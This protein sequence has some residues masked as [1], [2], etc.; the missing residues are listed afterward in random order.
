VGSRC[1]DF[2]PNYKLTLGRKLLTCRGVPLR[3]CSSAEYK[4]VPMQEVSLSELQDPKKNDTPSK[5]AVALPAVLRVVCVFG[6]RGQHRSATPGV[7][8]H[9]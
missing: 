8:A 9:N 2:K 1:T 7:R 6:T 3:V 4:A 5:D